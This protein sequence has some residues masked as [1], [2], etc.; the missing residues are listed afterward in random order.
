MCLRGVFCEC[1]VSDG[2][3]WFGCL[4]RLYVR[5]RHNRVSV[6]P[7]RTASLV[8]EKGQLP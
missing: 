4:M 5:L 3:A 2:L 7:T 6:V 1:L 8:R